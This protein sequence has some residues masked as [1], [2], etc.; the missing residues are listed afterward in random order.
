MNSDDKIKD[1][2]EF[3]NNEF[4]NS[5]INNAVQILSESSNRI[6]LFLKQIA[7]RLVETYQDNALEAL[8]DPALKARL[9]VI[10]F[11]LFLFTIIFP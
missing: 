7:L 3:A 5:G 4:E 9:K 11:F 10:H 6:E 2:I 8:N 1:V